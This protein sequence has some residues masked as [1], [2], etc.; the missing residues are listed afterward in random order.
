MRLLQWE[1]GHRRGEE[2]AARDTEIILKRGINVCMI[3]VMKFAI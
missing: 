2:Q 1:I 3:E